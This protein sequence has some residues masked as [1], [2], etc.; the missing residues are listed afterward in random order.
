MRRIDRLAHANCLSSERDDRQSQRAVAKSE[1]EQRLD[2]PEARDDALLLCV[3]QVFPIGPAVVAP[4]S[5]PDH[6]IEPLQRLQQWNE[7]VD[8]LDTAALV[9]SEARQLALERCAL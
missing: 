3:D 4:R 8:R 1:R 5:Q 9:P 6:A 2:Q 7:L